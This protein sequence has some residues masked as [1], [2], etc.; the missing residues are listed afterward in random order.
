MCP[1][2][3]KL[4]RL[5]AANPPEDAAVLLTLVRHGETLANRERRY[6]SDSDVSL[7]REGIDNL[8]ARCAAGYYPAVDRIVASPMLRC[9]ETAT[10]IFQRDPDLVLPE[11]KERAFGPWE[12]LRHVDLQEDESYQ[13]WIESA[14]NVSPPGVESEK[15]FAERITYALRAVL[16]FARRECALKLAVVTH[17]GVIM[18]IMR[19]A[20]GSS[21]SLYD[22]QL[23]VGDYIQV[24]LA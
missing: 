22:F 21:S 4:Y 15:S 18:E 11:L 20:E 1:T 23:S 6:I 13:T 9:L 17:G 14:G 16:E 10:V 12:G 24:Y 5:N 19:R 7:S 3:M 2:K 8:R